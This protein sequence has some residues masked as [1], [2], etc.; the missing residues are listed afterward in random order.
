MP[1]QLTVAQHRTIAALAETVA[2]DGA[3]LPVSSRE[4][5]VAEELDTLIGRFDPSPRR[6]L[7][8]LITA[9]RFAPV[10]RGRGATFPNLTCDQRE[11]YLR[12][13]LGRP[14]WDHDVTLSLRALCEM[15]Y[16]GDTRFREHVGDSGAPFKAGV[17][18]PTETELSVIC[19]PE[20][21]TNTT[22]ECDVVIVGSGAG[23][24]TIAREL[25]HAGISVVVVEEGGPVD[26]GDFS[27]PA[28]HRV[29]KYYRD[30][31]FTATRGSPV[32]PVP[33]GRVVGG[34]TVVNSGTCLRAPDSVLEGWAR[35]HGATLAAPEELG[36]V[37]DEVAE[38]LNIQPVTDDI[39]GNN[40][41][42]VRRG[43]EELKLRAHPIPRPTRRCVGT[44]QCAFGCPRDAKQA[45]HL[46]SLPEAV[47]RGARVYGGCRVDRL[48]LNGN[49]ITGVA[50]KI[51]DAHRRPTGHRLNVRAKAVFL[52]AGAIYTPW[53][54]R[55]HGIGKGS[56]AL[57]HHLRIHPGSGIT[58]KF[59]ET[60][61]G[62][63]GVMQSFA[64]DEYLEEGILLEATFPPLGMT[65]SAGALPGI[66]DEHA[67]RLN[68]Y[69]HMASLGSIVS[70]TSAGRV[71]R[72]LGGG[73]TMLYALNE[74][75]VQRMVRAISVAAR[76]L[77]A[78]G[79]TEVFP[80]VPAV[81]ILGSAPEVDA[82][83]QRSWKA[84]DLKLSAYHP[85]G[86]AR[87]GADPARS[88]CDPAGRVH[89]IENLYVG[90]TS[91]F[92]GSTHV[93]PQMTLMALCLNLARRFI[94]EW[95]SG[96]PGALTGRRE[97]TRA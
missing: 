88:V 48:I 21:C 22:V 23:G 92:P 73:P 1:H 55:C 37:Y 26:R 17:P 81:P 15:I 42:I 5:G 90:D 58:G 11:A 63:Q 8:L 74:R 89:D 95:P 94:D 16:A 59:D 43:A 57:G 27:D 33:M 9:A 69:P 10:L 70:D 91:L 85:M 84:S 34:T 82:F 44:G 71:R 78:A 45:M 25:A 76:V 93:N 36:P 12:K 6:M 67:S 47:A 3:G 46:T 7:K 40:G 32:I 30:N 31:G 18:I 65:Y 4:V 2:P 39:M 97:G 83:E 61:N 13:V 52:C 56:G 79:A 35:E 49:R 68:D 75:D 66:G 41:R 80:G 60:V 50:A 29:V 86:T 20:L 19:H 14:G 62:W 77:F 24:A 51:L 64:I 28:L 38:R 54:L 53:L 96:S 72:G 87:L